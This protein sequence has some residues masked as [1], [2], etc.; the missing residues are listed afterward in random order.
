MADQTTTAAAAEPQ[1]KEFSLDEVAAHNTAEDCWM[2]IGEEGERK[3]YDVTAFLDDHPGG[4]EIMV[5]LAGQDATA[6]FEDIGH[7]N[8]ARAQ[9][10][11]L[12]VGKVKGDVKKPKVET[13]GK[14]VNGRKD[15]SGNN[16]PLFLVLAGVV[17]VVA[18]FLQFGT[19]Q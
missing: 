13:T 5:D 6:E 10:V 2:I 8:D 17:G 7:S 19:A 16:G 15:V 14:T 1:L 18:L 9:L 11:P 3:V 12:L 4:P